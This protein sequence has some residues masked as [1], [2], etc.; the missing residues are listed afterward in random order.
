MFAIDVGSAEKVCVS[1][2][3][4]PQA[5]RNNMNKIDTEM[6]KVCTGIPPRYTINGI[7]RHRGR[8]SQRPTQREER[9]L[10]K[11]AVQ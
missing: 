10:T 11:E 8:G 5:A 4:V 3:C 6:R 1:V 9:V 7:P 2:I